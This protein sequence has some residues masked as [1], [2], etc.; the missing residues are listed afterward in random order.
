[1]FIKPSRSPDTTA[2]FA[3]EDSALAEIVIDGL[4][5]SFGA[6][7]VLRDVSLRVADGEFVSLLGPS[8]CGKTT[9]L[10]IVAGLETQDAGTVRITS[11]SPERL[12]SV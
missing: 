7:P 11:M 3:T 10:R 5:K 9:L 12:L 2:A 6:T 4:I 1:M 8:G